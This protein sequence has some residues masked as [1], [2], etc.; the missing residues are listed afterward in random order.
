MHLP[1]SSPDL[2]PIEQA[3]SKLKVHPRNAGAGSLAGLFDALGRACDPFTL[4]QCW[5]YLRAAG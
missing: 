2:T 4:Y 5:T 3:R 1:P